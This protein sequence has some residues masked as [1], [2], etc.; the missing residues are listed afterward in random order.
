MTLEQFSPIFSEDIY[1]LY[2]Q[3]ENTFDPDGIHGVL[4]IARSLVA[5]YILAKQTGANTDQ[6]LYAI[7]FHD[8]GRQGNGA[9]LWEMDSFTNCSK[10]LHN[11]N[12]APA[13]I[14]ASLILKMPFYNNHLYKEYPCVYDADVLEIMRPC[15]GHGGITGFNPS[16]LKTKEGHALIKPWWAFIQETEANKKYFSGPDALLKLKESA[17]YKVLI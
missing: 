10:Y 8:S 17:S 14:T 11:K 5:G 6:V 3:H 1:P 9:D 4:H 7:A 15:C 12:F 13:R 16:Y 2:K